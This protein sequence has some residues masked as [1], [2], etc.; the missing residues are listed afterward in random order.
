[1]EQ[2][3]ER[4]QHCLRVEEKEFEQIETGAQ[5]QILIQSIGQFQVS[6][7]LVLKEVRQESFS[8]LPTGRKFNT[9]ITHILEGEHII[10]LVGGYAVLSLYG[11]GFLEL[12]KEGK[13]H[14]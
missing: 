12:A 7:D 2:R 4:K 10:G 14:E 11:G 13:A 3:K 6:D 8:S 5:K 9:F 1:M